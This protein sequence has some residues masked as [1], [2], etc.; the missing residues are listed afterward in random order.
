MNIPAR[1]YTG[2]ISG[3]GLPHLMR[4]WISRP[5]WRCTRR[6]AVGAEDPGGGDAP[7]LRAQQ[8]AGIVAVLSGM[9]GSLHRG[10]EGADLTV[11]KGAV[12][13]PF[14]HDEPAIR[15]A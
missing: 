9:V 10:D 6:V 2:Y 13:L 1:Y 11:E 8:H 7:V 5:G 3:I 4:R 12:A 14:Q 15:L